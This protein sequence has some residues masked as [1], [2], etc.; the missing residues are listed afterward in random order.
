MVANGNHRAI[1]V[2]HQIGLGGKKPTGSMSTKRVRTHRV[3]RRAPDRMIT[4]TRTR[5]NCR[6][7][8][9][10]P[11]KPTAGLALDSFAPRVSS[12]FSRD[13]KR[14]AIFHHS[15]LG[16]T[17][18]QGEHTPDSPRIQQQL[19]TNRGC[20]WT[21]SPTYLQCGATCRPKEGWGTASLCR[22]DRSE[23]PGR[24]TRGKHR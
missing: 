17:D 14:C 3:K 1:S 11:R 5:I 4:S 10:R 16:V 8:V 19:K 6:S 12:L 2:I 23:R 9:C 24:R 20:G 15:P 13:A 18:S 7:E 22:S 21:A